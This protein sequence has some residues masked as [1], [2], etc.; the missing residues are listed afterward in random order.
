M[1]I[2]LQC[3]SMPK[4][5]ISV[6]LCICVMLLTFYCQMQQVE[7][8]FPLAIPAAI[9]VAALFTAGGV[10]FA[11]D[12]DAWSAVYYAWD[13]ASTAIHDGINIAA[14]GIADGASFV[15]NVSEDVWSWIKGVAV[16]LFGTSN[17]V[18]QTKVLE[19]IW[20]GHPASP[21]PLSTY[22]YQCVFEHD[23]IGNHWLMLSAYPMYYTGGIIKATFEKSFVAYYRTP[24][25]NWT[26]LGI[27]QGINMEQ[28]P[29]AQ[30]S[31]NVTVSE[32]IP[33]VTTSKTII[34][35]GTINYD[36]AGIITQSYDYKTQDGIRQVAV[37][38]SMT[39]VIGKTYQDVQNPTT[40]SIDTWTGTFDSYSADT[41]GKTFTYTGTGSVAIPVDKTITGDWAGQ[42][43]V[44][45]DGRMVWTGTLTQAGAIAWTG[46][47]AIAQDAEISETEENKFNYPDLVVPPSPMTKK[48]P[49]SIPWDIKLALESLRADPV[50]PKWTINFPDNIFVGG[51][52]IVIDFAQFETW[53]KIIRWGILIVFNI[54]LILTTRK[55]IG[56]GG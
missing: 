3:R 18:S 55:V 48:F 41:L 33:T 13:N 5:I 23:Y 34:G 51:G 15:A 29:L 32:T 47:I 46:T 9:F 24:Q 43:E 20:S 26:Y 11:S 30:S 31:Y 8:V 53:A 50:A 6:I 16:D 36:N 7:A 54:F 17:T 49:F 45:E 42:W 40:T 10:Y 2:A 28:A 56:A 38:A 37:P 39:D 25:G 4:K 21:Y 44:D 22:P 35:D 52:E 19:N 14:Q 12:Q 1:I 27:H